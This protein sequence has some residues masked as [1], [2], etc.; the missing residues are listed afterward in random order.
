MY[1]TIDKMKDLL[2]DDPGLP[3]ARPGEDQLV[4]VA[5]YGPFLCG[6]QVHYLSGWCGRGKKEVG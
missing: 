4:A 1:P 5:L 2:G 3:G 6:V